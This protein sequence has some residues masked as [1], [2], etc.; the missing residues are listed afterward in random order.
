ML[1]VKALG[2]GKTGRLC[3]CTNLVSPYLP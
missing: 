3:V 1:Y 2:S